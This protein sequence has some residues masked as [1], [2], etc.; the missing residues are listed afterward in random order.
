MYLKKEDCVK[1]W[2]LA[3]TSTSYCI[4]NYYIMDKRWGRTINDDLDEIYV[5]NSK[6]N[7]PKWHNFFLTSKILYLFFIAS[8]VKNI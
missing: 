2:S 5:C 8:K 7:L 4:L 6:K 1:L 3:Q